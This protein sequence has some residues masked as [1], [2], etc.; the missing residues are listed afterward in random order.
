VPEKPLQSI[1]EIVVTALSRRR[2]HKAIPWTLS[3]TKEKI[4]APAAIRSKLL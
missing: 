2:S 1:T 4:P 3:M